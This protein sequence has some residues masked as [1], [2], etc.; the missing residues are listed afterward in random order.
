MS[1][2]VLRYHI[3]TVILQTKPKYY[4]LLRMLTQNSRRVKCACAYAARPRACT[5]TLLIHAREVQT[6][7]ILVCCG[8]LSR[9][10]VEPTRTASFCLLL[11]CLEEEEAKR[12]SCTRRQIDS[13]VF[14]K[15]LL[16]SLLL[17][18]QPP[19]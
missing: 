5:C 19:N 10:F 12:A 3:M 9:H 6:L 17:S 8:L 13:S 2:I 11:G 15:E 18:Q 14:S 7:L 16:P 4:N 1:K